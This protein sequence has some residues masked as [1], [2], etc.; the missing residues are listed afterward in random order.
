M[1]QTGFEVQVQEFLPL[2]SSTNGS[3]AI[4]PPPLF[5]IKIF[6]LLAQIKRKIKNK[7]WIRPGPF[8]QGSQIIKIYFMNF[9]PPY[10]DNKP[11]VDPLKF[12]DAPATKY[13]DAEKDVIVA[14]MILENYIEL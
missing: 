14:Q 12:A 5:K 8:P 7:I 3:V 1:I 13:N 4:P 9:D 10:A 11:A 2:C 6:Q